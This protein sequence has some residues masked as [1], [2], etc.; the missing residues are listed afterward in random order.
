M[1]T[2]Y[3]SGFRSNIARRFFRSS[4]RHFSQCKMRKHIARQSLHNMSMTSM[5]ASKCT[6]QTLT[7]V[8]SL[9]ATVAQQ[10][11][12]AFAG[13][14]AM[15]RFGTAKRKR[16]RKRLAKKEKKIT[17]DSDSEK[18][19]KEA[20]CIAKLDVIRKQLA[21]IKE[22]AEKRESVLAGLRPKEKEG[23]KKRFTIERREKEACKERIQEL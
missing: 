13:V 7:T 20:E 5:A 8:A 23:G 14:L 19:K 17:K 2:L 18:K 9:A 10:D 22:V 16:K 12:E 6:V 21:V 4:H 1:H 11:N 15:A 3:C